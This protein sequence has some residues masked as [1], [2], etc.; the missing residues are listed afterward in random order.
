MESN[1]LD[2]V[3]SFTDGSTTWRMFK[4]HSTLEHSGSYSLSKDSR[5]PP[6]NPTLRR[7]SLGHKHGGVWLVNP[8]WT[9]QTCHICGERGIRV[10]DENSTIE[11]KGGEYFHCPKCDEHFHADINAA[12]NIMFVQQPEPSAVSGRT[13]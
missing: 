7:E 4:D 1:S 2:Y 8:A 3:F 11:T 9:S 5:Q 10:E 13:T 6:T 12:R